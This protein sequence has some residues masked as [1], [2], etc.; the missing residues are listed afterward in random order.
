VV[1]AAIGRTRRRK[2]LS[3]GTFCTAD[4]ARRGGLAEPA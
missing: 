1:T 2:A 3:T 4:Q